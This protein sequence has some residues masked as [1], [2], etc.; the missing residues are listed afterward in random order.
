LCGDHHGGIGSARPAESEIELAAMIRAW[1]SVE[2]RWGLDAR[3]I[4]SLFPD[5]GNTE[6]TPPPSAETRM[7]LL[8]SVDHRLPF[9][10]GE[11]ELRAWLRK[12]AVELGFLSPIDVMG[13][14]S[15]EIRKVRAFA[16]WMFAR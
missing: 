11:Y 3:E 15:A 12:P 1:R 16:E 10:L 4:S 13:G 9:S 2:G 6:I 8:L 5:G 7:R 14:S